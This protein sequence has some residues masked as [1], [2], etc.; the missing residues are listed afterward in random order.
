MIDIIG[1][2]LFVFVFFWSPC[3]ANALQCTIGHFDTGVNESERRNRQDKMEKRRWKRK[4]GRDKKMREKQ[5]R[6]NAAYRQLFLFTG[7]PAV[8]VE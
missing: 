4:Y 3:S 7:P 6:G 8:D 2:C 5:V 1:V